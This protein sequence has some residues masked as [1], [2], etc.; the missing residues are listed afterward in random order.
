VKEVF[1]EATLT[2]PAT[3]L[4]YTG[5]KEGKHTQ[6]LEDILKELQSVSRAHPAATW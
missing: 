1:D 5:G 3:S 2:V 6:H 4:I